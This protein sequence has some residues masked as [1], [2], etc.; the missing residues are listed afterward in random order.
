MSITITIDDHSIQA[1]LHQLS[2]RLDN[3]QPAMEDIGEE[4]VHQIQ[5]QL[6]A[7]ETPWGDP[8]EPLSPGYLQKR[9]ERVGGKPLNDTHQHIFNR[10]NAQADSNSVSVG[11]LDHPDTPGL[12]LAHQFG[13]DKNGLPARPYLPIRNDQADLPEDWNN[14][15]LAILEQHLLRAL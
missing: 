9:P 7:G 13:S 15:I 10:I 1:A 4:L 2:Q 5:G 6:K 3:L 11:L 12:A 14:E 8:F